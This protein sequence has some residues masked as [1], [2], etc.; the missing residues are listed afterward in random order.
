MKKRIALLLGMVLTVS[1]LAGC[2]NKTA[3]EFMQEQ[4]EKQNA[5]AEES[6]GETDTAPTA[7]G[8]KN[9]ACPC[10]KGWKL[11]GRSGR[12][13]GNCTD[14][15]DDRRGYRGCRGKNCSVCD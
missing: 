4:S 10:N 2:T 5:V 15:C 6:K 7:G 12:C 9:R 3:E 11:C 14:G 13:R 1:A 8:V